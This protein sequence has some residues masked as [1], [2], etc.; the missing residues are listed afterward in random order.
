MQSNESIGL[1]FPTAIFVKL[2]SDECIQKINSMSVLMYHLLFFEIYS[3]IV[4]DDHVDD[5]IKE[6][7]LE[8]ENRYQVINIDICTDKGHGHFH[9]LSSRHQL[10]RNEDCN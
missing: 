6:V 9:G 7:C 8:I 1:V 4:F 5:V 2:I 3:R 10:K